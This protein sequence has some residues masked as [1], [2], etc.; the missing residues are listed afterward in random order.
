MKNRA[1][2]LRRLANPKFVPLT[3]DWNT[4]PLILKLIA[5]DGASV[6]LKTDGERDKNIHTIIIQGGPLGDDYIRLETDEI[7]HG[8]YKA[9]SEYCSKIWVE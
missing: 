2:L 6:L 4:V 8:V 7:T 5:K 3:E 9:A 1:E